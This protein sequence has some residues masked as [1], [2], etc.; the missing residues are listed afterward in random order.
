MPLLLPLK[1]PSLRKELSAFDEQLGSRGG[2]SKRD[3]SEP[4][5]NCDLGSMSGFRKAEMENNA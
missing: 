2:A 4:L 1:R 3:L 5:E